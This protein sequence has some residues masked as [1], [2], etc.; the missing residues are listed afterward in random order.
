MSELNSI[1]KHNLFDESS[2]YSF[3]EFTAANCRINLNCNIV[4]EQIRMN[5]GKI[6]I[7]V[8]KV[9]II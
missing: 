2:L 8:Y 4:V 5:F 9:K 1:W 3:K 6:V 7:I